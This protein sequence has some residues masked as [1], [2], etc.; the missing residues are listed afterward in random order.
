MPCILGWPAESLAEVA[1]YLTLP[2]YGLLL[3]TFILVYY[4]M[5]FSFFSQHLNFYAIQIRIEVEN[6]AKS[7]I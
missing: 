5:E 2:L 4:A 3:V 1:I 7:I 6:D